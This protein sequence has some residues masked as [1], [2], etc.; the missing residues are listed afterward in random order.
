MKKVVK[1]CGYVGYRALLTRTIV[2]PSSTKTA[3]TVGELCGTI[4]LGIVD[5]PIT[6]MVILYAYSLAFY[7][8]CG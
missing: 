8:S 3:Q 2:Q 7:N 5:T 4:K 6:G 1:S